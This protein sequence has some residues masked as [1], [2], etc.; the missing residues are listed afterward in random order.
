MKYG[1]AKF[2]LVGC[3]IIFVVLIALAM[4]LRQPEHRI[5]LAATSLKPNHRI[6]RHDLIPVPND[7]REFIGRY[8]RGAGISKWTPVW[9]RDLADAPLV[10]ITEDEVPV[11]LD[12]QQD[13]ADSANAGSRLELWDKKDRTLVA[14][15]VSVVAITC[16]RERC[17]AIASL[18]KECAESLAKHVDLQIFI[19]SY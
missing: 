12:L 14:H 17:Q 6:T 19:T 11:L 7:D 2:I 18:T 8:V 15:D 4:W 16:S 1:R 9:E 10:Q 13:L 5:Y 3:W